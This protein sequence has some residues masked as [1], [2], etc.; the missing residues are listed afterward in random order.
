[1]DRVIPSL[2]MTKLDLDRFREV[3][4]EQKE[5][6]HSPDCF[7]SIISSFGMRSECK[8]DQK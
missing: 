3:S 8:P 4:I 5:G 6:S 7:F 1:M 2:H